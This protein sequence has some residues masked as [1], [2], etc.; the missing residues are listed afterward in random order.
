MEG[1]HKIMFHRDAAILGFF[2]AFMWLTLLF[3]YFSIINMVPGYSV[4]IIVSV[5]GAVLLA[6][7]SSAMLAVFFHLKRNGSHLYEE[8]IQSRAAGN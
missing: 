7:A 8:E 6:F 3:V 5:S 2:T 4:K 1:Q